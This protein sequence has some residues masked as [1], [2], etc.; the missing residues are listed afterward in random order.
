MKMKSIPEELVKEDAQNFVEIYH[1]DESSGDVI[2][3]TVASV[4]GGN[5]QIENET[6]LA[7]F[8][9]ESF[10]TFTI[11]WSENT[12]ETSTTARWT[13]NNGN[14]YINV[15]YVDEK[16][17]AIRRP[18]NLG[19]VGGWQQ[20]N[21]GW[22]VDHAISD[23]QDN[24]VVLDIQSVLAKDISG[25]TF[26]RA[27]FVDNNGN[28]IKV[29]NV[30]GRRNPNWGN[31][32]SLTYFNEDQANFVYQAE[33]FNGGRLQ[34]TSIYLEYSGGPHTTVHY[35]YMDG[36]TFVEFDE[37]PSPTDTSTS[38]GWA[39][40]IYDF[41]GTDDQ[42][43]HVDWKYSG[44]YYHT[45]VTTNPTQ[46][47]TAMSPIL[48]YNNNAWRYYTGTVD[49]YGPFR[50][51]SNWHEVANDSDIYVV[52]EKPTIPMGGEPTLT[53]IGHEPDNPYIL[54]ESV[55]NQDGTNTLSLSVTGSTAPMEAEKIADVIAI[56]DL[57]SSMRRD[58]GSNTAYDNN[59]Q[60][61]TN[62]R[63]YQAKN[64][65]QTLADT[66]YGLNGTD[67]QKY[68]LGLVTFSNKGT[69]RQTPTSDQDEFQE[70]LD[71]IT[72]YEG[73]GTN[74][75]HALQLANQM[76]VASDRSTYIVFITDGEPSVR[77]TRGDLTNEQLSGVNNTGNPAQEGDIF[78]G[79]R[80]GGRFFDNN[81]AWNQDTTTPDF[82][83]YLGSAT[84]GGLMNN[85]VWD[86]RNR[87][88]CIDE[89]ASIVGHNKGFY[90]IGVSSDVNKLGDVVTAGGVD[91]DHYQLVTSASA[92]EGVITSI[93]NELTDLD[94]NS[95]Q[96]DV[97]IYDGITDLTQTISKVNQNENNRLLGVDGDFKYYKSTAPT[98]WS[99]WTTAQKAAYGKGVE[100]AG[101]DATPE[102]YASYTQDEIDA[103]NLGK[104]ITFTEWT[105][106]EA[107]GC[108]AA[109]YNND[110]GAV[111]WNMGETF[112]LED[113]VTYKVSFICWPSQ[114]AYDI[115]AKLNNGTIVFGDTDLYPQ[116]IWN[117]FEGNLT[118]GY[119]LKTNEEDANTK[120]RDATNVNGEVTVG[121]DQH[122]LEF[123]HVPP[124]PLE[125]D[126][127]DVTKTWETS[128]IDSQDPNE[129]GVVM[130]V[131]GDDDMYKQFTVIP[132]ETVN[133]SEVPNQGTFEDIYISCGHLKVN[134]TT[135]AVVIYESGHDFTLREI[136]ENSRHWDLDASVCRPMVINT[137][138][139]MLVLVKDA[140]VPA[141]MTGRD[142]YALGNDEYYRIDGKV[143]K[144]THAWADITGTNSRRSFLDL[145]K[146]ILVGGHVS[147]DKVDTKF[148]YKITI[149]VDPTTLSWDPRIENYVIISIRGDGYSP[150]AAIADQTYPTT[151]ML[152]SQSGMDSSLIQEG[153]DNRYLVAET[154]V[155][156]YLSIKN[157]WSVRFLNLPV[158]TTYSIEE[159]LPADSDYEF[160]NLR[161]E[162]RKDR[163]SEN[164]DTTQTYTVQTINGTIS[165][166]ST[167]YKVVYQ[168]E[169]KKGSME[170][171][172]DLTIDNGAINPEGSDWA[173]GVYT[174]TIT[175]ANGRPAVGKVDGEWIEDGKVSIAITNGASNTVLVT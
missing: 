144:D 31:Y 18:A 97:Q 100:Y 102:G 57:S 12:N 153:D 106:R 46:G 84:F 93:L 26:S 174:F 22:Y 101:S 130:Q 124:M 17:N 146:E 137:H 40:L 64:A 170:I 134:T 1:F 62:S 107:D 59:Y 104:S 47:G 119:R 148:T 4:V 109:V 28:Q 155:E 25:R 39:H 85:D 139:T 11:G 142:Y 141:G 78:H 121:D 117:Q 158:G 90:A 131:W 123:Q 15:Y 36:D 136:E 147:E 34:G 38:F 9:L 29:T 70:V 49:T 168:N 173:D 71:N 105:T 129:D 60:T 166:T 132:T 3:E 133:G 24:E 50:Q 160:N 63:Y 21:N 114:E 56:L 8:Q 35:G 55:E 54:K 80:S 138:P 171:T 143:F 175:D 151:A 125:K 127:L 113:G 68:R 13:R 69:V 30:I 58:I 81:N 118:D 72:A 42:G 163:T 66:L 157:G 165:E 87:D 7:E 48:R 75:E 92:F 74:W 65:V 5:I 150:A 86:A 108:A 116:E 94:G 76:A 111:E 37:Q 20:G 99:T 115:I 79:G 122:Q 169:P 126:K 61:V 91:S 14:L 16:G 32:T 112:M 73:S 23:N 140:E 51:D 154:G 6:V 149:N 128:R 67:G 152:P 135:G 159:V 110:T 161:L 98:D 53:A 43:L 77:Q 45:S 164:P 41:S 162:T 82:R 44:T 120:Y 145:G 167:L 19:G 52:Y 33:G 10:S 95:G 103:F 88:A 89:I 96:A 156:F 83:D 27:Y 172:K 2:V